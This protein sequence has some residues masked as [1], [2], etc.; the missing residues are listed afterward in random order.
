[1]SF[2]QELELLYGPLWCQFVHC[3]FKMPLNVAFDAVMP[4]TEVNYV[5]GGVRALIRR[6]LSVEVSSPQCLEAQRVVKFVNY[7]TSEFTCKVGKLIVVF[8]G[9]GLQKVQRGMPPSQPTAQYC[10]DTDEGYDRPSGLG[11][12]IGA[13]FDVE[14]VAPYTKPDAAPFAP[15]R[16]A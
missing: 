16:P 11:V 6:V 14:L 10:V 12:A 15:A 2:L 9:M 3:A 8:Q 5:F 7:I 1:M 4:L 13:L